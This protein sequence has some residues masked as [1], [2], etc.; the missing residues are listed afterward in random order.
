MQQALHDENLLSHNPPLT[1]NRNIM[2]NEQL[3]IK[4]LLLRY[5]FCC[6]ICLFGNSAKRGK[7]KSEIEL[8]VKATKPKILFTIYSN[9]LLIRRRSNFHKQL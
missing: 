3:Y 9:M 2:L 4:P 1:Q 7:N 6:C 5:I 8:G